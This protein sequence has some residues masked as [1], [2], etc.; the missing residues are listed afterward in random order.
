EKLRT[1]GVSIERVNSLYELKLTSSAELI[2]G[3]RAHESGRH[4]NDP[5]A[6]HMAGQH[7]LA[8]ARRFCERSPQ[9]GGM[10]A[11]RT[12]HLDSAIMNFVNSGGRDIV[13]VGVGWDMRPFRLPLPPG[14]R[15][16]E[17]DFPT[18]LTERERRLEQ[19]SISEPPGITRIRI[20]I[21]V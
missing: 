19:L 18:T 20:P 4:F 16:F 7:G 14:T 17:L 11:A 15:V 21:D 6:A 5:Y 12:W 13:I 8:L 10:V 3:V 2:A 1:D 9:L